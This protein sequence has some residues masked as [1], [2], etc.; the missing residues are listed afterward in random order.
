VRKSVDKVRAI[1]AASC[2]QNGE[3]DRRRVGQEHSIR[4]DKASL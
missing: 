1:H 2:H 4:I 3:S